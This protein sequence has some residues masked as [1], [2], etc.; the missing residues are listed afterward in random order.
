[1]QH[2]S[3]ISA[4]WMIKQEVSSRKTCAFFVWC[5]IKT[6]SLWKYWK[7]VDWV[8]L[9]YLSSHCIILCCWYSKVKN[10]MQYLC[11]LFAHI[12]VELLTVWHCGTNSLWITFDIRKRHAGMLF[13][14]SVN[15][16][17]S[18]VEHSGTLFIESQHTH[19]SLSKCQVTSPSGCFTVIGTTS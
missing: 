2:D 12:T 10:L 16:V 15:L 1:M 17:S 8:T 4:V 11:L 6:Q 14:V 19:K 3:F 5:I 18:G 9:H 13:S 7:V